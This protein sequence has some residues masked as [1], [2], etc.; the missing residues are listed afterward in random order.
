MRQPLESPRPGTVQIPVDM[1][2]SGSWSGFQRMFFL[3]SPME[4]RGRRGPK[5]GHVQPSK[6]RPADWVVTGLR[7][8]AR[9]SQASG[10][11]GLPLLGASASVQLFPWV[12]CVGGLSSEEPGL[13]SW[14]SPTGL[15][16]MLLLPH[17]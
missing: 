13:D 15:G 3:A 5:Q 14:I 8:S 6:L 7:P 1:C 10:V 9:A 4:V 11:M 12:V 16:A 2:E 17:S